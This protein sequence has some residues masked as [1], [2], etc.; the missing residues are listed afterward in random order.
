MNT[1]SEEAVV[2]FSPSMGAEDFSYFLLEKPGTYFKIGA[3]NENDN[4]HFPHHHPRF[5]FDEIALIDTGKA[6]IAIV[7]K[8]MF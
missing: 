6:F 3:R 8:D 5:D 7:S 2:E 4:T 1:F